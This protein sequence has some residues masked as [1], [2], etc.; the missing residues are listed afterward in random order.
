MIIIKILSLQVT[1]LTP[2]FGRGLPT[3]ATSTPANPALA[4][5]QSR[6]GGMSTL[7]SSGSSSGVS[8][9]LS[10]PSITGPTD[11]TPTP[12]SFSPNYTQTPSVRFADEVMV[13]S[14]ET[15]TKI[16]TLKVFSVDSIPK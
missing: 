6:P 15:G 9:G 16:V 14:G 13:Q 3:Y 1:G 11:P 10:V 5:P 8:S 12:S 4:R 7:H 2:F